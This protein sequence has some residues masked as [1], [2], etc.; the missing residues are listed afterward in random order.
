MST[1]HQTEEPTG[2]ETHTNE[3]KFFE[4]QTEQQPS[5]DRPSSTHSSANDN[6]PSDLLVLVKNS[7][8]PEPED[9]GIFLRPQFRPILDFIDQEWKTTRI[10]YR[11]LKSTLLFSPPTSPDGSL[12]TTLP[13]VL[14]T[15]D[16]RQ[17]RIALTK[18]CR[19]HL[20]Q[21]KK[22]YA[23]TKKCMDLVVEKAQDAAAFRFA[24]ESD[25]ETLLSEI[26][27]RAEPAG[28]GKEEV[29]ATAGRKEKKEPE[30]V[31]G[32]KRDLT[33]RDID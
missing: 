9:P 26:R 23:N 16:Q 21:L 18:E 30:K 25:P 33:E 31:V 10:L 6:P 7:Q 4:A 22:W 12:D 24:V 17:I 29:E 11:H 27:S 14:L 20:F 28:D 13:P 2:L 8:F 19:Q 5:N 15:R 3:P 1:E 32:A